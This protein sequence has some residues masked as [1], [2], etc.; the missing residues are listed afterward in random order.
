MGLGE[1]GLTAG[2]LDWGGVLVSAASS[3]SYGPVYSV[4]AGAQVGDGI[5]HRRVS[6]VGVLLCL[7]PQAGQ[8]GVAGV[9]VH[10][11]TGRGGVGARGCR[12][13][14]RVERRGA[15]EVVEVAQVV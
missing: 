5:L 7:E 13:R 4:L 1:S 3:P 11:R 2:W 15:V 9:S 6:E 8:A 14:Y 10:I 12:H